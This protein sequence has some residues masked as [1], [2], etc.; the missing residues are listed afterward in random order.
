MNSTLLRMSLLLAF[1]ALICCEVAAQKTTKPGEAHLAPVNLPEITVPKIEPDQVNV[2]LPGA[3]TELAIGGGGRYFVFHVPGKRQLIVFDVSQLEVVNTLRM[4]SDNFCYT[5]GADKLV[6]VSRDQNKIQSYQLPGLKEEQS[7]TLP[8]DL[9]VAHITMGAAS[10]GPILLGADKAQGAWQFLDLETLGPSSVQISSEWEL[11]HADR[12]DVEASADGRVF[13]IC[14]RHASP[15]G[16]LRVAIIGNTVETRYL[17]QTWGTVF[18]NKDGSKLC[19]L[20]GI[21]DQELEKI[22]EFKNLIGGY[23]PCFSD[24]YLYPHG[25]RGNPYSVLLPGLNKPLLTVTGPGPEISPAVRHVVLP[26]GYRADVNTPGYP[27]RFYIEQ[28]QLMMFV[29]ETNDSID[30]RPLNIVERLKKNGRVHFY[31]SRS[32]ADVAY[33]GEL[34]ESEIEVKSVDGE[35]KV[36]QILPPPGMTVTP[37]G[38]IRWQVP[39]DYGVDLSHI[40]E[41]IELKFKVSDPYGRESVIQTKLNIRE[42]P[43][44]FEILPLTAA[45]QAGET[46][47]R[48]AILPEISAS[49][50]QGDRAVIK[51]PRPFSRVI[52][53][54]GGRYLVFYLPDIRQLALFDVSRAR[55]VN[56]MTVKSGIV[57]FAAGAT[58][59]VVLNHSQR[60]IT[61]YE[62]S[63]FKKEFARRIP[64]E[65]S[66]VQLA[67]GAASNGPVYV[68]SVKTGD[69]R[70]RVMLNSFLDLESLELIELESERP[71]VIP[72]GDT[73][74]FYV[75]ASA[76]GKVFG[77]SLREKDGWEG[78]TYEVDG[79][80]LKTVPLKKSYGPMIPGPDGNHIFASGV[81][82][83]RVLM[84]VYQD[85]KSIY[86]SSDPNLLVQRVRTTKRDVKIYVTGETEP[87][88]TIPDVW[89][90]G[91]GSYQSMMGSDARYMNAYYI[92]QAETL[93]YLPETKSRIHLHRVKLD[94]LLKNRKDD[95]FFTQSQP[96]KTA[97][98]GEK[99]EYK[100]EAK[101]NQTPLKFQID[102]GPE[103][104]SVSPAGVVSWAV[105]HDFKNDQTSVIVSVSNS[106]GKSLY[107]SYL[108]SL[109][110]KIPAGSTA[111]KPQPLAKMDS[112]SVWEHLN[113]STQVTLPKQK[114]IQFEGKQ[115]E[116]TLPAEI[117]DLV[118]GGGGRY[119]I[120]YFKTLHQL[121]IFDTSRAEIVK[122]LPVNSEKVMF[123]AGAEHLLIVDPEKKILERWSLKTFQREATA[124]LPIQDPL[125]GIAIG[126][127]SQGPLVVFVHSHDPFYFVDPVSMQEVDLVTLHELLTPDVNLESSADRIQRRLRER[128]LNRRHV[129][130]HFNGTDTIS[131]DGRLVGLRFGALDVTG[132]VYDWRSLRS[133]GW[134]LLPNASGSRFYTEAG[135]FDTEMKQIGKQNRIRHIPAVQPGYYLTVQIHNHG[136]RKPPQDLMLQI[137]DGQNPQ[138]PL[139]DIDVTQCFGTLPD[140]VPSFEKRYTYI[141][142]ADLLVQIPIT[143]D[144]LI[145]HQVEI[146]SLLE[147]S[148]ED[149]LYVTSL[150]PA[151]GKIGTRW[152][153][154]FSA[155]SKQQVSYHLETGP[156]GMN[157]SPTGLMTWDIR[158]GITISKVP[159][160]VRL[161]SQSGKELYHSFTI[162]IPEAYKNAREQAELAAKQKAAEAKA[163]REQEIAL[164]AKAVEA[165]HAT[166]NRMRL[167]KLKREGP[168]AKDKLETEAKLWL[169]RQQEK[170]GLQTIPYRLWSDADGNQIEAQL[171][172]VFGGIVKVRLKSDPQNSLRSR[173]SNQKPELMS[174]TLSELSST[175]QKYVRN[176]SAAQREKRER[177]ETAAERQEKFRRQLQLVAAS[178]RLQSQRSIGFPP[179]YSVD[180]FASG[181]LKDRPMLSW[182]VHLLPYLGGADLY[183]LFRQDEPWNSDYN[184]RLIALMPSFYQAPGSTAGEGKTNLLG[185]KGKDCIFVGKNEVR[186]HYVSD[187]LANTAMVVVVPDELAIEWTRPDDWE[188]AAEKN[189]KDLFSADSNVFWTIFAD[190]SV[191]SI[192]NQNSLSDISRIFTIRDGQPVKLK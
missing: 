43:V 88:A 63:T 61:R 40:T 2:K 21:Y 26:Q 25:G 83:N 100:L 172:Q 187:G 17:D 109:T 106:T 139:P 84:P 12:C 111:P 66:V 116:L 183:N 105:P 151:T 58:K 24:F 102:S 68:G 56:Y 4:S 44:H 160:L 132:P 60:I 51:L 123:A 18:P 96:V 170:Q 78:V 115:K 137:E 20:T 8:A 79:K 64:V 119:L 138:F 80:Q 179:A 70:R 23:L 175:D 166:E 50:F 54:G 52:S 146:D 177:P 97:A 144:R 182:R 134:K 89:E 150:A 10:N 163:Q 77:V 32:P 65:G 174:F 34:Y 114:A 165:S 129:T 75:H 28:A 3:C 110:G 94:Q 191:R 176:Y 189:I 178:I 130:D 145:L 112:K 171:L 85:L 27:R 48:P 36:E 103:G 76:N 81:V 117:T 162:T 73:K 158:P 82:M 147:E 91:Y 53:G 121:G 125:E 190:G 45:G 33:R 30:V 148:G 92:P 101:S 161:Q 157:V 173:N 169:K 136:S 11:N 192:S 55:V 95:Y 188:Y 107:H 108:L 29:A 104:M 135:I 142:T 41:Q 141:P 122:F 185:V 6:I 113:G 154:Q 140:L 62:L 59:L 124:L 127:A 19:N 181:V 118:V 47:L 39:E 98:R 42:K 35:V 184:R 128:K 93:A 180:R 5:A 69:R 152:E 143:N 153:C 156:E 37:E 168:T 90:K 67:L 16:L 57:S 72:L 99:Y 71:P 167:I 1:S 133:L 186:P 164:A 149:Y 87:I 15:S 120:L 74:G 131:A 14:K 126:S 9:K 38:K 155:K 7:Q 49:A 31:V 159:V 13:G 22:D 86:P 46:H